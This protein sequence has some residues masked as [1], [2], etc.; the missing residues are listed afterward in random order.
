MHFHGTPFICA[1]MAIL[2]RFAL[3]RYR[4]TQKD[5]NELVS[6]SPHQR[7]SYTA[8]SRGGGLIALCKNEPFI[9]TKLQQP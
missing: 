6:A 1:V 8:P 5:G 4:D 3:A 9:A 2:A 7:E